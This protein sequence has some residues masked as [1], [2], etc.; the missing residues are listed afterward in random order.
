MPRRIAVNSLNGT[1]MDIMNVIRANASYDYQSQVPEVTQAHEIPAV[2][3]VIYGHPALANQYI[4]ALVNRIALYRLQSATFNNPYSHLKK[5]YIEFGETIED[6]FVGITKVVDYN[7]EKTKEREFKRTMPDVHSVFHIMNWRVMYP[8]TIQDEDLH[9]AFLTEGGMQDLIGKIVEQV[10]TAAEYD[11][12]L[13]FKYL[14]IKAVAKKKMH[15]VNLVAGATNE[16]LNYHAEA[17]RGYSNLLEFM[18]DKYNEEGVLTNTPRDRQAI[19][20]DALYNAQFDVQ[21]LSAAFHMDKADFMGRLHLIDDFTTFDNSRFDVIRE[22]C[23]NLEEVT[24]ADLTAMANVKAILIDEKWFQVYDNNNK[25]TE[26]YFGSGLYWNY[27]YH[28]WKT[29]SYSPFANAVVFIEGAATTMPATVTVKITEKVTSDNVTQ[30]VVQNQTNL[31]IPEK[32]VQTDDLVLQ[33]ISV[34]PYGVYTIPT[35]KSSFAIKPE[36]ICDDGTVYKPVPNTANPP[37]TPSIN[38]NSNVGD[39]CLLTKQTA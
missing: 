12:F 19:F 39:T 3:E 22:N 30:L 32:F 24:A 13:L 18:K 28:I 37:V 20:M 26:N 14:I 5:G 35:G 4:N 25:F 6:I 15:I 36:I 38:G 16:R 29:I 8:V 17:Y 2:G 33:G 7:P 21:E 27:F 1:T 34:H 31:P 23:D 10:Y 11:E 9:Q